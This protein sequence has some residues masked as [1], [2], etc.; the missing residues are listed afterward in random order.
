MINVELQKRLE[1]AST[2]SEFSALGF[3]TCIGQVID[4][5]RDLDDP[6]TNACRFWL[7]KSN[8]LNLVVVLYDLGNDHY[9]FVG[10]YTQDSIAD[11]IKNS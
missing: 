3:S 11:L 7:F 5:H 10:E 4:H 6:S 8:D 1:E 2:G 9:K